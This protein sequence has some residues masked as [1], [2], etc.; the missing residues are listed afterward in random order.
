[1]VMVSKSKT[2]DHKT[3][4]HSKGPSNWWFDCDCGMKS[5]RFISG[6]AAHRAAGRH[7]ATGK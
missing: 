7:Q 2:Y 4:V 3:V 5:T 6:V 1:M